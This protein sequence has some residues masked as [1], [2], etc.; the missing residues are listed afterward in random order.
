MLFAYGR[1]GTDTILNFQFSRHTSVCLYMRLRQSAI[2][3]LL[4]A[5][6]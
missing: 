1:V 6:R 2:S 4:I 5:D 3:K